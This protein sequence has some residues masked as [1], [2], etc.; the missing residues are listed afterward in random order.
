MWKYTEN[1]ENIFIKELTTKVDQAGLDK[2]QIIYNKANDGTIN[3]LYKNFQIG[4]VKFGKKTSKMQFITSKAIL[5]KSEFGD[6]YDFDNGSVEWVQNESLDF[7]ISSIE[8][9][10]DY[11]KDCLKVESSTDLQ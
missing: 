7:Y 4:R 9:W 10:I 1:A 11:T 2:E 5:V 3:F 8:K 6:Y